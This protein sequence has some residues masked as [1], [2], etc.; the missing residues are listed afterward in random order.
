LNFALEVIPVLYTQY[1]TSDPFADQLRMSRLARFA[2]NGVSRV[3]CNNPVSYRFLCSTQVPSSGSAAP[4]S[5]SGAPS[6]ESSWSWIPPRASASAEA[7]V[8]D[9]LIP[10]IPG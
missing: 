7:R 4:A 8:D 5:A 9:E 6:P 3:K 1:E 2:F 10:V